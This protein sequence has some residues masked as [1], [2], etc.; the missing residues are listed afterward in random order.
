MLIV[1]AKAPPLET[2]R[3]GA[4]RIGGTRVTLDM[5]VRAFE[6]G[7]TAEE[8]MGHYPQSHPSRPA[9]TPAGP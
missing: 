7:H 2:N 8:I 4:M 3:N 1:E 9:P 6:Q 5:V